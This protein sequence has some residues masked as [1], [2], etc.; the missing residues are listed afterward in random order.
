M[1]KNYVITIA[2][3]YGS[4]G[5]TLGKMLAEKLN[6]HYYDRELMRLASDKSGISE[7]IFVQADEKVKQSLLDKIIRR[8]PE[9]ATLKP[10][11]DDFLSHDN[12]FRYQAEVIRELAEEES[13]VI[14]GRCADYILKDYDNVIK[15]Y[16]HASRED[17]LE[18]LK[19][20]MSGT[21][22]ELEKMIQTRDKYRAEYYKYH[23]GREWTDAG[24]Y[25]L[26]LNSEKM[27]FDTCVKIIVDYLKIRLGEDILGEV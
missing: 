4:G 15:I 11:S 25:D 20:M 21:E 12:L 5:K 3:G 26:C 17:C 16:V 6:I 8:K 13:C 24:N 23:T 19:G 1:K 18:R 2:R 10:D 27:D 14:V 9:T 7:E 22:K